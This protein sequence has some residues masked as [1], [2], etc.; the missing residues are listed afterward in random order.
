M[1]ERSSYDI[2]GDIWPIIVDKKNEYLGLWVFS[3]MF[4]MNWA[5]VLFT[6]LRGYFI[7]SVACLFRFGPI[8]DVV[9]WFFVLTNYLPGYICV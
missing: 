5:V 2:N 8:L 4:K 1:R 3:L 6:L 9:S 7:A